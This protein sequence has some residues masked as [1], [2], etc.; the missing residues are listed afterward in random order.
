M[1]WSTRLLYIELSDWASSLQRICLTHKDYILTSQMCSAGAISHWQSPAPK[2]CHP[3]HQMMQ[4]CNYNLHGGWIRV[5]RFNNGLTSAGVAAAGPLA[6]ALNLAEGKP[7]W[8]WLLQR[9]PSVREQFTQ[10]EAQHPFVYAPKLSF[11]SSTLTGP[12]WA[13]LPSAAGFVDPLLST[14]FP[15][16][17]LGISRLAEAIEHHWGDGSL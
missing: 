2:I 14:G 4:L 12:G 7:A 11:R 5:L 3:I 6:S 9:L 8:D 15:L 13:L 16:T 10:A 17:L 1:P